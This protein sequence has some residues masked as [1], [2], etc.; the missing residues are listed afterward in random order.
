MC[1][2]GLEILQPYRSDREL[3]T[4]NGPGAADRRLDPRLS[5]GYQD[6]VARRVCGLRVCIVAAVYRTGGLTNAIRCGRQLVQLVSFEAPR[7][8]LL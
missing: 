4:I 2:A 3:K 5:G 1:A 8:G 7:A 6:G